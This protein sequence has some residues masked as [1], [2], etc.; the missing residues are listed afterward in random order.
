MSTTGVNIKAQKKATP[1]KRF[2]SKSSGLVS[3]TQEENLL[4]NTVG[5]I[6]H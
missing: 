5:K 4:N 2:R 1:R 6:L 3:Q